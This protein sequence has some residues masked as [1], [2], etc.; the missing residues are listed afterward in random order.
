M[1]WRRSGEHRHGVVLEE[2]EAELRRE[3]DPPPVGPA[4]AALPLWRKL[5]VAGVFVALLGGLTWTF[6]RDDEPEGAAPVVVPSTTT[7]PATPAA[8]GPPELRN[9]GEDFNDIVRS[10]YAFE[11]WVYQHDPDPKYVP[12]F[13]HPQC[14]CYKVAEDGLASL[15]AAGHHHDSPGVKIHKVI[16]RDRPRPELVTLYVIFE[17][18]PGAILDQDGKV[19]KERPPLAPTGFLEHWVRGEDGRWRTY[20]TTALGPPGEGWERW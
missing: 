9:T 13:T 17:G 18:L 5:A 7:A 12:L 2:R 6:V 16:L 15:K 11:D 10:G 4:N 14:E 8:T 1:S 19:V 20:Q 3:D